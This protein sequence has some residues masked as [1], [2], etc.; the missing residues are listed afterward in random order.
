MSF[1]HHVALVQAAPTTNLE[2]AHAWFK[3]ANPNYLKTSSLNLVKLSIVVNM[4]ATQ[5][6]FILFYFIVIQVIPDT[7]GNFI[8]NNTKRE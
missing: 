1:K 6:L 7:N 3:A 5:V 2:D 4:S 8:C